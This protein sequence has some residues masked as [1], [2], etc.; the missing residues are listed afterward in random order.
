MKK[1]VKV[2]LGGWRRGGG[3]GCGGEGEGDESGGE[4]LC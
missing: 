2:K 3:G 4:R 1:E